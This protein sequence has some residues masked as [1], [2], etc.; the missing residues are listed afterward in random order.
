MEK[1]TSGVKDMQSLSQERKGTW[2]GDGPSQEERFGRT[3]E[4]FIIIS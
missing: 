4:G 3:L 2:E 1:D